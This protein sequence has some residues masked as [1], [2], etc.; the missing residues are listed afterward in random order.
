MIEATTA[1]IEQAPKNMIMQMDENNAH[2]LKCLYLGDVILNKLI[3][4]GMPE[5]G[6]VNSPL[7]IRDQIA[8]NKNLIVDLN[9]KLEEIF[10]VIGE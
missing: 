1:C 3:A 9:K 5:D 8:L 6:G 2:L 10:H 4:S 7:C